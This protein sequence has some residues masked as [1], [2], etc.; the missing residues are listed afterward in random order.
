MPGRPDGHAAHGGGSRGPA[1]VPLGGASPR[2]IDHT[3]AIRIPL[4]T[5]K[6]VPVGYSECGADADRK[7]D[8][9]PPKL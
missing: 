6:N 2:E 8:P 7:R 9:A 3:G 5:P 1:P 4:P